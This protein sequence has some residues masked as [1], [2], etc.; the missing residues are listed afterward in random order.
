ME[1]AWRQ[2]IHSW[3]EYL[4]AGA[5]MV[6]SAGV[7]AGRFLVPPTSSSV[8]EARSEWLERRTTYVRARIAARTGHER[9][10]D[11]QER[12]LD[13]TSRAGWGYL[14]GVT[15]SAGSFAGRSPTN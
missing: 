3:I 15:G 1:R 11:L 2:T 4:E 13:A 10:A 8:A 6:A 5:A 14:S 7:G 9:R 12:P